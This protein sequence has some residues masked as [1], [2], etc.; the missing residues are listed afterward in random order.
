MFLSPLSSVT[1][2]CLY[3][4]FYFCIPYIDIIISFSKPL[5]IVIV[6]IPRQV[7][8]QKFT[9]NI[10]PHILIRSKHSINS[11]DDQFI[12]RQRDMGKADIF[13]AVSEILSYNFFS[14]TVSITT[15]VSS[16]DSTTII[17]LWNLHHSLKLLCLQSLHLQILNKSYLTEFIWRKKAWR[18]DVL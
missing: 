14:D 5:Q 18:K 15:L 7:N 4:N 16:S 12:S 11:P 17:L 9:P 6:N 13:F 2:Y 1:I 10:W 3:I 8:F